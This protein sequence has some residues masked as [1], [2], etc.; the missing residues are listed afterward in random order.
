ML[1]SSFSVSVQVVNLWERMES[2]VEEKMTRVRIRVSTPTLTYSSSKIRLVIS[3]E[4]VFSLY[5]YH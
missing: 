2:T 4:I 3:I 1:F 5:L